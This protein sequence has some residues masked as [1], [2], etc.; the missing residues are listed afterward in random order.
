MD[1][2]IEKIVKHAQRHLRLKI[3]DLRLIM[4]GNI[5][6]LLKIN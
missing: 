2:E 3:E 4:S 1:W 6:R 5:K